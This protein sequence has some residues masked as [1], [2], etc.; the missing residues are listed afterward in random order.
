[1]YR[2]WNWSRRVFLYGGVAPLSQIIICKI[3][4]D[5]SPTQTAVLTALRYLNHLQENR[6]CK[7][8]VVSMSLGFRN[9]N[10]HASEADSIQW[11]INLLANQHTICVA[12]V[13]EMT[14]KNSRL[15][16]RSLHHVKIQLQSAHTTQE[17]NSPDF[18]LRSVT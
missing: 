4:N 13:L 2:E 3:A 1:M 9:V 8:H 11:Q 6:L 15:Q 5:R 10:L 12:I 14:L 7:I 17:V 16:Y 18:H